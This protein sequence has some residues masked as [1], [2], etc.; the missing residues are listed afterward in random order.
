MKVKQR[1]LASLAGFISLLS[2]CGGAAMSNEKEM[3]KFEWYAVATAP[4]DYPME[5]I[6][7]TFYYKGQESGLWIPSGGTLNEGWGE[8][9]SVYV[10]GPEFKPL[11]DRVEVKFY[12]YT[13]NQFYQGEFTL[14]YDKIL[15]VFQQ[16]QRNMPDK[17]YRSI[18]L[19]I[20][21]GGAVSVWLDGSRTDE[22][23]FGQAEKI[24]MTP[25]QAFKLPFSSKEQSDHYVESALAES[26]T[27][28]QLAY[29]KEHGAPIGTW[30]RFRN[31]YKWAPVYADEKTP[32]KLE[33][34]ANFLNG[35]RWWIPTQFDETLANSPKVLPK[36]VKFRAGSANLFYDINF[37]PFEL[38]EAFEK[39]GAN[40]EKVFIEF[41]PQV[42]VER[43]KIR[44]YNEKESI[45][46]K[47]VH[48]E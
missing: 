18:L 45:E 16:R 7:G 39:L 31:R 48:I 33:M 36:Q 37:E 12:S 25:S 19:G 6:N 30:A 40:G 9:A 20:A 15:D 35:E 26:V 28:E 3:T 27:P 38:M 13:E 1:W 14:P 11:P 17:P 46:L 8:S 2:G 42:P 34:A 10:V 47:K 23:F 43:M 4:R 21:P 22:V 32:P 24:E 29:I 41:D 44:V 5:V